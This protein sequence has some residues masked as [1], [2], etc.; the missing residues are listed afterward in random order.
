MYRIINVNTG[1]EIG[2]MDA[3]NYIKVGQSGDFSPAM[4]ED[5]I[6]VAVDSIPY[7]LFGHDEIED[8]DTV[9]V[10]EFDGGS[11]IAGQRRVIDGLI[12]TM[13]EG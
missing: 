5:A 4:E 2:V 3:V 8:A 1:D 10:S 6:G 13:L 7:N 9:I 11:Y 12:I